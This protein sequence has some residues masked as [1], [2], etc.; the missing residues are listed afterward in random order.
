LKHTNRQEDRIKRI[1]IIDDDESIRRF[2]QRALRIEGFDPIL[3]EGGRAAVTFALSES[4]D[5]L[6]LDL[7]MPEIDGLELL[8]EMRT[9][10][11]IAPAIMLSG[12]DDLAT[13][14]RIAASDV[15]AHLVKPIRI[16]ELVRSLEH[17]MAESGGAISSENAGERST[18]T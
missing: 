13:K 6:L 18:G 14:Q 10:G 9:A 7:M 5:V 2:L 12:N 16:T 8:N 17:A 3:S 4:P 1:L 15:V 11:V